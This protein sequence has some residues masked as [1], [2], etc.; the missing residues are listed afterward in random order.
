MD[1]IEGSPRTTNG[2]KGSRRAFALFGIWLLFTAAVLAI[3]LPIVRESIRQSGVITLLSK[4]ADAPQGRDQQQ[5]RIWFYTYDGSLRE[6]R[7]YQAKRGGSAYHDTFESLLAG[8]KL[9]ALKEGAVSCI[10]HKTTLKGLTLSNKVLYIDLSKDFW[11]SQDAG[12]AYEQLRRTG[13]GFSQV[14]DIVLLIE[15]ERAALPADQ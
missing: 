14:K 1:D 11:E 15:G 5:T 2:T 9:Q 13:K 3:G 8:P 6:F 12:R 4:A 7:Q 10:H